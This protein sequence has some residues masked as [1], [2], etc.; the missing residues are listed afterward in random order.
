MISDHP[1]LSRSVVVESIPA[2]GLPMTVSPTAAER[3]ALAAFNGIV[4]IP[5]LA[6]TL[7]LRREGRDG[8]RVTGE[9][10]GTV[11]VTCVVSLEA[12]DTPLHEPVDVHFVSADA[13]A[14]LRA[15][16][17]PTSHEEDNPPDEP[18]VI[19]N[20][21]ID[22]GSLVAEHLTLAIDPYPRKPDA[23]LALDATGN[24]P[25]ASPFAVLRSLSEKLS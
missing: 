22:V 13:L 5:A 14:T 9:V 24:E 23:A 25:P 16:S 10:E 2:A 3:D 21:R 15:H 12:F 19:E 17:G 8:V 7:L 20:G 4:A 1:P 11:T 6:A 18:D